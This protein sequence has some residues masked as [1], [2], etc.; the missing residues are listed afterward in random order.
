MKSSAFRRFFR[1][2]AFRIYAA[3]A[4]C[5]LL[6]LLLNWLLNSFMFT[7]YYRREK[8]AVLAEEFSSINALSDTPPTLLAHLQKHEA[9][10]HV[11]VWSDRHVLFSTAPPGI[12]L[13]FSPLNMEDGSYQLTGRP[14]FS[15]ER[16]T[17]TDTVTLYGRTKTGLNVVLQTT[18]SDTRESTTITNRFLLWSAIATV[19]ISGIVAA[20]LVHSFNKPVSRLSRMATNMAAMDFSRRYTGTGHGELEELGIHLNTMSANMEQALAELK[21]ANARLL[22]EMEKSKAQTEAH[23]SF[24][25]NVSHEL[26]TPIA[27]IQTYSEGLRENA[28]ESPEERAYYCR[29]IESEAAHLSQ[30]ISRMTM[31]MQ[32]QSGK[33]E[34]QIERFS[35][36]SV[37]ERL[38]HRHAPLF[39]EHG[40][41][42]PSLP[43]TPGLVWGDGLLIENVLTNYLTNA[44]HHVNEGGSITLSWTETDH[45]T[46]RIAVYNT[47]SHIPEEDMAHLWESFYKVDKAHTRAY[48]GT[49]IGLSVVAAIMAVHRMPY[50]VENRSEGVEFFFELPTK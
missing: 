20:L 6:L 7:A 17:R 33:A 9:D 28:A 30:M 50:G 22:N 44:L 5:V 39:E 42:L 15:E 26:K 8:E 21:T 10:T 34:L 11:F 19:L 41:S 3:F 27:L 46:L 43:D 13:Q 25:S 38:L 4:L 49:G 23:R 2:F 47:G 45:D 12:F 18:L 14:F 48:G 1:S 32:L 35:I 37:C 40:I 16:D 31:L 29:V 24:I 36:Q